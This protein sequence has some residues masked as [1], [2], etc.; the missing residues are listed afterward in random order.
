[1]TGR[2]VLALT[3]LGLAATI[4][5]GLSMSDSSKVLSDHGHGIVDLQLAFGPDKARAIVADWGHDGIDAAHDQIALDWLFIPS[6]VLLA[7]SY[8]VAVARMAGGAGAPRMARC[9]WWS[10]VT[11]VVVGGLDVVENAFTLR[12]LDGH[13]GAQWA[14]FFLAAAKWGLG[15]LAAIAVLSAPFRVP[16]GSLETP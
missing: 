1:V 15:L 12:V 10:A 6:Y 5:V 13:Y 16:S 3:L 8:A 4:A 11:F 9:A 7:A 2:R 14:V